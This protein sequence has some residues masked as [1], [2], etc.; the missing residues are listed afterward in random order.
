MKHE[1]RFNYL[2]KA[3]ISGTENNNNKDIQWDKIQFFGKNNKI[4]KSLVRMILRQK[5]PTARIKEERIT[6]AYAHTTQESTNENINKWNNKS[7]PVF[8]Y[9][10]LPLSF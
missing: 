10:S 4:G 2:I 1:N 9:L 3:E 8:L 7:I 6:I 5:L